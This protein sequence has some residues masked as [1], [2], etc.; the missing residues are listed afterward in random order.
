[1]SGTQDIGIEALTELALNLRWSWNRST[2]DLW[3]QLDPELWALTHNP[4]DVLQTASPS[5]VQDLLARP[6][7]RERVKDLIDPRHQ[8]LSH[9]ARCHP[10]PP[11][12]PPTRA[13]SVSM[14]SAP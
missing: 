11:Q 4:W 3:A 8:Y 5:R 10:A 13:A 7:F 12:S 6:D 1:M 14:E 2:D 9:P